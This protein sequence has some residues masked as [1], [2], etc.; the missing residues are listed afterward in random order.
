MSAPSNPWTNINKVTLI[1]YSQIITVTCYWKGQQSS[2]QLSLKIASNCSGRV[3]IYH[4]RIGSLHKKLHIS[5]DVSKPHS[6]TNAIKK[7]CIFLSKKQREREELGQ[8]KSLY[9]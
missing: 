7:I 9:E 2:K 6:C 5:T 4:N 8:R 1:L 3:V